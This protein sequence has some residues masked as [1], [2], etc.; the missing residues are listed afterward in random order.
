MAK[1][2][3]PSKPTP[4]KVSFN[5]LIEEGTDGNGTTNLE[6]YTPKSAVQT[7]TAQPPMGSEDLLIPKL[8]LAQGLTAEV[9]N[10]MAKAGQWIVS[11]EDPMN[12]PVIIPML[13]TRRRELR[14]DVES[15]QVSCRSNDAITGVGNPGGD[16]SSCPMAH[17]TES[18]KKGGSNVPP[19]CTFIYSYMVYVVELEQLV[20]LEF[21]RTSIPAGKMLNTMLLQKGFGAFGVQLSAASSKAKKGQYYSP[22]VNGAKV[23]AEQLKKAQAATKE[24]FG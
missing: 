3:T 4:K 10:G 23:T 8:R 9:T 24:I 7:Y 17:W 1:R 12:K 19:A 16:C 5:E 21:S 15:R 13:M 20:V 18:K 6:V 2:N 11:G 14:D 22:V